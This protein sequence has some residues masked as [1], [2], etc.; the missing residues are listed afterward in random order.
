M[1]GSLYLGGAVALP[2]GSSH[3]SDSHKSSKSY[4]GPGQGWGWVSKCP[5]FFPERAD[6]FLLWHHEYMAPEIIRS[7]S[8]HGKVG[9]VS[10]VWV[11]GGGCRLSPWLGARQAVDWWSLWHPALRAAD[12]ALPFT[13]EGERNTQA[14]VSR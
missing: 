13:L 10:S 6:L 4:S 7:K 11:I 9:W 5:L 12:G 2:S 3:C 1:P 14:E 8:G